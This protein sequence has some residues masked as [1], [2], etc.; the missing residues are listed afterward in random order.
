MSTERID[1]LVLTL[2]QSGAR[3][4]RAVSARVRVEEMLKEARYAESLARTEHT[5]AQLALLV[6]AGALNEWGLPQ[7]VPKK[8]VAKDAG[9]NVGPAEKEP[10]IRGSDY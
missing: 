3:L 2:R 8:E 10:F 9:I 7:G 5:E 1:H 4:Q 6:E